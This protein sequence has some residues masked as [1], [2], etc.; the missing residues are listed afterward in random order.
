MRGAG[1]PSRAT[2]LCAAAG[3]T[4]AAAMIM[5]SGAAAVSDSPSPSLDVVV[6]SDNVVIQRY[7]G[8]AAGLDMGVHLVAKSTVEIHV[9]RDHYDRPVSAQ[10]ITHADGRTSHRMLPEGMVTGFDGLQHFAVLTVADASG[11]TVVTKDITLCPNSVFTTRTTVGAPDTSP[12]PEG[13]AANPFTLGAVWGI[14]QGWNAPLYNFQ[15]AFLDDGAYRA[16]VTVGRAYQRFFGIAAE[17]AVVTIPFRI[18]TVPSTL[19][20][21]A[22]A[23]GH[24][25][26][27]NSLRTTASMGA[28]YAQSRTDGMRS[29]QRTS[30]TL[31]PDLR[32]LPA[33]GVQGSSGTGPDGVTRSYVD[34]S[35]TVWNAGTSPL[36]VDGF[37]RAGSPLM[38]AYQYFI[39]PDGRE[40]GHQRAGTMQWDPREG[41]NHWHF[42]DFARYSLLDDTQQAVLISGK[43]AF[44]LAN[45]DLIDYTIPG[46]AWRP[47]NVSLHTS[48]GTHTAIGV[49]QVLDIGNG[50]TYVQSLPGQSFDITDVPN[51]TYYIAVEANPEHVLAETSTTNNRTL[52]AIV[53]SGPDGDRHVTAL[54]YEGVTA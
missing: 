40:V 17:K 26:D 52:R 25:H 53:I 43:E 35:A 9:R 32:A 6:A 12:Y 41:H 33:W 49:R 10:V 27:G 28:G 48:C 30:R 15:S 47:A 3:V 31:R 23:A 46:A 14:E 36:V 50:D 7:E 19:A 4:L 11:K 44:C 38:D 51:G 13:C 42:T 24:G 21:S 29:P 8:E 20:A 22:D 18:E 45:T 54:P 39:G 1:L 2:K 37:R 16:T 34:F 5:P